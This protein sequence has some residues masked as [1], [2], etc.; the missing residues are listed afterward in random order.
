MDTRKLGSFQHK[1]H[2][3]VHIGIVDENYRKIATMKMSPVH[4]DTRLAAEIVKRWN[5]YPELV[6]KAK[7]LVRT[8]G[9][10]NV[11]QSHYAELRTLLQSLNP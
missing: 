5:A 2:R 1:A 4:E 6:E 8:L 7:T 10:M 11:H 3:P 9:E